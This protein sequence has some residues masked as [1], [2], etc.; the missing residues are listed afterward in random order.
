[1]VESDNIFGGRPLARNHKNRVRA[2]LYENELLKWELRDMD[3]V[4]MEKS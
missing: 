4:T 2:N 1:V 3:L